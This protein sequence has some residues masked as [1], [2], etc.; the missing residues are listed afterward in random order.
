MSR[1]PRSWLRATLAGLLCLLPVDG[2]TQTPNEAALKVALIYNF[3]LF[4]DWP[5]DRA[6]RDA[7]AFLLCLAGED[8]LGSAVGALEGKTIRGKRIVVRRVRQSAVDDG[9][10]V[11][12]VGNAERSRLPEVAAALGGKSVLIISDAD[13]AVRSGAIIGLGVEHEKM[14]FD[15]NIQAARKQGLIVSSKLLRLSRSVVE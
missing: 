4:V 15:V 1:P 14:V 12:F 5:E 3:A 2:R 8:T 13:A 9:C 6:R 7:N 10:D 11:L